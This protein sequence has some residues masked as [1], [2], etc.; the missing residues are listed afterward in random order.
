M[1]VHTPNPWHTLPWPHSYRQGWLSLYLQ[2][3]NQRNKIHASINS[4]DPTRQLYN[5]P[6]LFFHPHY[7][8]SKFLTSHSFTFNPSFATCNSHLCLLPTR[9]CPRYLSLK[10]LN[11]KPPWQISHTSWYGP[12]SSR[13]LSAH[14]QQFFLFAVIP[15]S[16]H[17]SIFKLLTFSKATFFAKWRQE[18]QDL[19]DFTIYVPLMFSPYL[20]F[21]LPVYPD[22]IHH[23]LSWLF[24][25]FWRVF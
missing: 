13:V 4:C 15:H 12:F 22:V 5:Y 21:G 2:M 25:N 9:M 23:C 18:G 11:Q 20:S 14:I 3:D 24:L 8:N 16:N 1:G 19:N 6:V 17:S 10:G 7:H